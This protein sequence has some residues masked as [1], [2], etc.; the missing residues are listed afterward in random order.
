MKI[1]ELKLDTFYFD[2]VK[3]GL[4]K[5]EIRKNDRDFRIGDLLSLSRFENGKYL[6]TRSGLYTNKANASEEAPLNEADTILMTISY[7]TDY[8]QK[9]GYVVMGIEPYEQVDFND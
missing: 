3:N 6:K 4:K 1:H 8:E 5:F 9:D 7:I 2:E